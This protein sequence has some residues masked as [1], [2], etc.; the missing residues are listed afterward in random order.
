MS[1]RRRFLREGAAWAAG[2]A[3]AAAAPAFARAWQSAPS[4]ALDAPRALA[5][6]VTRR[7]ELVDLLSRLVAVSSPLGESAEQAQRLVA[8]YLGARDYVPELV[9]DDPT[10]YVDHP[11]YMAPATP[12]PAPATNLVARPS[13]GGSRVGLFAHIDTERAG[14]GWTG[15]P[16]TARIADGRA[17]GLG[18]ADDKGG[19]AAMLVA[20]AI[21]R[22]EGRPAPVVMSLHGKGGGSRGSLP[23]FARL[24][25]FSSVLYVHPAETGRG[26]ADIKH[27]VRGVLDL[28]VTVT[29]WRATPREIGSP[30]SAPWAEGGDALAAALAMIERLR[31]TAFE[32]CEVNVGELTAGD[33]VGSVPHEARVRL[34]VLWNDARTFGDILEAARRE[35]EAEAG[36]RG[37]GTRRLEVRVERDGLGANHAA[38][39]WDGA[40]ARLLREAITSVSGTAPASYPSH[41]AG[42]IRYPIRLSN[43]PAFGIGSLAGGFYGADEWVDIEDLVRLVAVV[44]LVADWW[45]GARP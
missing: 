18:T 5:L 43:V 29:G 27:V 42:D 2:L 17:Y 34:R 36:R 10:A 7:D 37:R 4:G 9:V 32:R 44:I 1:T 15:D 38:V 39:D 40:P 45:A 8:D 33:R 12:Y 13:G 24:R 16:L 26:L 22:E 11:D 41:F 21:L 14:P 6:A 23:T 35:C 25:D 19:V 30:D 31:A 20:A 28:R 3:T